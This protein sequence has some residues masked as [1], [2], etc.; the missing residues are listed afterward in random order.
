M[1]RTIVIFTGLAVLLGSGTSSWGQNVQ[2]AKGRD[3]APSKASKLVDVLKS[4]ASEKEK[5]DAC[6]EL[7][8]IG[9]KDSVPPLAALLGDEKLS[10]Y[11]SVRPRAHPR[12]GG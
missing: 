9:T 12:P 4:S 3:S 5:A 1:A 10:A 6:L 8:R 7:G 2:S 11:G